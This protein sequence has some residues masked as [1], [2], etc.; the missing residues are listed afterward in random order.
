M[1]LKDIN[2]EISQETLENGEDTVSR[3][4]HQV[5]FFLLEREGKSLGN[6]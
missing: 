4:K 5:L 3:L 2:Y 6:W 1:D